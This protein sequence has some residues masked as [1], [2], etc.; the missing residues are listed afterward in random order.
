MT[1]LRS[2]LYATSG[3]SNK[4][5]RYGWILYC[6]ILIGYLG[7]FPIPLGKELL[8][9]L[10]WTRS[11]DEP[12]SP[13]GSQSPQSAKEKATGF[14][15]G[16]TIGYLSQAGDLIYREPVLHSA[17]VTDRGFINYSAIPRN[18]VVKD[19]TG[20]FL[21]TLNIEGYPFVRKE[22]LFVLATDG[23][24]VAEVTFEGE[25]LWKRDFNQL[26]TSM[27]A[28]SN[29]VAIGLW[30]G[31]LILLG[32]KGEELFHEKLTQDPY[33]VVYLT[34]LTKDDRMMGVVFGLKPQ[35][36]IVWEKTPAGYKRVRS[37]QLSSDFRRPMQGILDPHTQRFV[38]EDTE[39]I[40]IA[41]RAKEEDAK[42]ILNERTDAI[43]SSPIDK[44]LLF[45]TQQDENRRIVGITHKGKKVFLKSLSVQEPFW[46]HSEEGHFFLGFKRKIVKYRVMLG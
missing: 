28:G 31:T 23:C 26:I 16:K 17:V 36:G 1:L 37:F 42:I 34:S 21:S 20:N 45:S 46:F 3:M 2:V 33:S 41:G 15:L 7:L 32:S 13:S 40:F 11:I 10:Q 43:A 8:L 29:T 24:G 44:L 39:G 6:T 9:V 30:D 35:R 18:L 27:D 38:I 14:L 4:P 22:R 25:V 12:F 5:R 19:P